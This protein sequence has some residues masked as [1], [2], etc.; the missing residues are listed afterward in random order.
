MERLGEWEFSLLQ[1]H[2]PKA[3]QSRW[4]E[5]ARGRNWT[6]DFSFI[7]GLSFIYFPEEFF[8]SFLRSAICQRIY[9][10]VLSPPKEPLSGI[11]PLLTQLPEQRGL[12]GRLSEAGLVAT[13][14]F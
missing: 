6:V 4:R 13:A 9:I 12:L 5:K 7:V 8:P 2:F 11:S 3:P 10:P 1:Q 14:R